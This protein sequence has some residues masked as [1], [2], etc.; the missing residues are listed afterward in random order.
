[1]N[2]T[3]KHKVEYD[4]EELDYDEKKENDYYLE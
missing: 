1:M 3:I 2:Q 4:D